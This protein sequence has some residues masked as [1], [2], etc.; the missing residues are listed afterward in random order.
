MTAT[1]FSSLPLS[2]E[3]QHNLSELGYST[4]TPIQAESLPLILAGRDVLAQAQTG[5]G[6]TL[7][8]GLGIMQKINPAFFGIQG[9]V[10]CP[11]RELADQVSRELRKLARALGN[12]KILTLCGG[13]ALRPQ[14]ESLSHGAH[15]VV[16]TPGR[17]LDLLE[18][19]QLELGTVKTLVLDEA[20]RM[21]DM[22][23]YDDICAITRACPLKRQTLMF[24]ATYP[25]QILK[26]SEGFMLNPERVQVESLPS[27]SQ[28]EQIFYEINPEQRFAA[29]ATLLNH[30]RPVSTLAFCNTKAQCEALAEELQQRGIR[31][32]VLHGDL[33]QRDREDVLVQFINQSCSVL[34]ATDVA[35][36]GLDIQTL[37]AVINVDI[38]PNAETH[39]HR[40]GRTGRSEAR[41]LALT[42]CS[43]AEK[44]RAERIEKALDTTLEWQDLP[45]VKDNARSLQAPMKTICLRAG[46]KDKIRPGDLLGALT[47]DIGLQASQVGK[48]NIYDFVAFVAIERKVAND[49]ITKLRERTIKGKQLQMRFME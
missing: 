14:I 9:L 40:I 31:A 4:M 26:D 18:R 38:S 48:I 20:D 17:I 11:T 27:Q 1:S 32:L 3:Q 46:K 2:A 45:V 35:A 29:T 5:S 10:L 15:I 36:R 44:F 12:I 23:F 21:I 39:I 43:Q 16:G 28:I 8:F 37:D 47:K 6:K 13:A 33:E 25:A 41:G 19:S 24:S 7:A 22:G 42:L 34:V 49:T 30:F